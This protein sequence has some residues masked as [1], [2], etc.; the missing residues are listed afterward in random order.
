[1]EVNLHEGS[2]EE[3]PVVQSYKK[4]QFLTKSKNEK[5]T[6]LCSAVSQAQ[7]EHWIASLQ[8]A[9]KTKFEIPTNSAPKK[10]IEQRKEETSPVLTPKGG[11]RELV[12]SPSSVNTAEAV[13]LVSQNLISHRLV[14]RKSSYHRILLATRR[15]SLETWSFIIESSLGY[16]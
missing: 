3:N 10:K 4:F 7:K 6:I 9:V 8:S 16:S 14:K 12:K 1:V 11:R 5:N 2:I 15:H 13:S